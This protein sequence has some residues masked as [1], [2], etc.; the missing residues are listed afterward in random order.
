MLKLDKCFKRGNIKDFLQVLFFSS[1]GLY[2]VFFFL[3]YDNNNFKHLKDLKKKV[4]SDTGWSKK[5]L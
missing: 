1:R 2:L 4:K 5:S 3:F